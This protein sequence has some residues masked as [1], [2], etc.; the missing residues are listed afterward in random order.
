MDLI[1]L[2]FTKELYEQALIFKQKQ[3]YDNYM[4]Y[5]TMSAN[6]E[7]PDAI[8]NIYRCDTYLKQNYAVTIHFYRNCGSK[9]AYSLHFLAYMH[10]EGLGVEKD[11]DEAFKLYQ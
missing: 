2:L 5:I 9:N 6:Y 3:D 4:I 8:D 11:Y 1:Y 7:Y 10:E